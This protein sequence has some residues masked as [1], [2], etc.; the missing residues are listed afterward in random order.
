MKKIM[1]VGL[2]HKKNDPRLFHREIKLIKERIEDIEVYMVTKASKG[3]IDKRVTH[4]NEKFSIGDIQIRHIEINYK[5]SHGMN[6]I[7]R[8][9]QKLYLA[10]YYFKLC[11]SIKPNIIQASDARELLTTLF[12]S[13]ITNA[14]IIYDS[15]EDYVSQV[16]DY[17]SKSIKNYL[18]ATKLFLYELLLIR[19]YDSIFCTDEFL[20]NKYRK[21]LYSAKNVTLLRNFPYVEKFNKKVFKEKNALK[22]VYI[23]FVNEYRGVLEC[24]NYVE[25][26]NNENKTKRITL[27]VYSPKSEIVDKLYKSGKIEYIPWIDYNDLM[28]KLKND[29]DIGICLWHPIKKFQRN[30]PLKNFD[31][32]GVGLPII[33]SNFGNLKVHMDKSDAG[34]CIDPF[35]Y[36]EFKD[37]INIMFDSTKREDFSIKGLEYSTREASF[38]SEGIRYIE[39]ISS[40]MSNNS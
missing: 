38:Q 15:H 36:E 11:K 25:K 31:Y 23:G 7:M 5:K 20:Y 6:L 34:I 8:L 16:L 26:Y 21:K 40:L 22:L 32:M 4:N 37:A 29:Y 3:D 12:L 35:S 1:F 39:I 28:I 19:S 27:D 17:E 30:L 10:Y 2:H 24:A 33:T 13:V 18:K 14:S 9:Y